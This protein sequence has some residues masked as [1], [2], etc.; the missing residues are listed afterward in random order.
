MFSFSSP[1]P[2]PNPN[3]NPSLFNL[4]LTLTLAL[5]LTL[6]LTLTLALTLTLTTLTPRRRPAGGYAPPVDLRAER[7][8]KEL[9]RRNRIFSAD[10]P[11][12]EIGSRCRDR[13]RAGLTADASDEQERYEVREAAAIEGKEASEASQAVP[14]D[15]SWAG[16]Y[17]R[18]P[19]VREADPPSNSERRES[20]EQRVISSGHRRPPPRVKR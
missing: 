1:S 3:P 6:T 12:L 19:R 8:A 7:T 15:G 4:T 17:R 2:S 18:P 9:Q 13:G 11:R 14:T 10:C 16:T 20:A 5:T